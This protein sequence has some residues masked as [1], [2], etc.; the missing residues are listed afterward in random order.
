MLRST[1]RS[2]DSPRVLRKVLALLA[3]DEGETVSHVAALME[4]TRQTVINWRE[5]WN[6]HP[7]HKRAIQ[8]EERSGRPREWTEERQAMLEALIERSPEQFGYRARS[9]TSRLLRNH[10]GEWDGW[11][12][13]DRSIRLEL[14]QLGYVYKRPR[15]VLNPD[16]EF[17]KKNA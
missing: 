17:A 15:Y 14:K 13:S 12:P 9:W 16:P 8:E 6:R 7:G 11:R 10:L 1:L 4:V 2:T 3:L 5:T